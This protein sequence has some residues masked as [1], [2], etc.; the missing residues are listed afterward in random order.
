MSRLC[1]FLLMPVLSDLAFALQFYL[2]VNSRKCLQEDIHKHVLLTGEY[3]VS[4]QPKTTT[5]LKVRER[6]AP[7][8]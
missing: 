3:Q 4:E 1:V 7:Q 5:T 8:L 2:P 6:V